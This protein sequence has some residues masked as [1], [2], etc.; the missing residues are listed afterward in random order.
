LKRIAR[1]YQEAGQGEIAME[2]RRAGDELEVA[3]N[4]AYFLR[5]L[6]KQ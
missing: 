4:F 5:A 6:L 3:E 2:F 1:L